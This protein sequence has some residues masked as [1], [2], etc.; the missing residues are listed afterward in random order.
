MSEQKEP[1]EAAKEK[2]DD[3]KIIDILR[4]KLGREPNDQEKEGVLR[5]ASLWKEAENDVQA[6]LSMVH[7]FNGI[8]KSACRELLINKQDQKALICDMVFNGNIRSDVYKNI[9]AIFAT[10]IDTK[11]KDAPKPE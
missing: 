5:M 3:E 1:V 4:G 6:T 11:G 10:Q 9:V 2:T 7:M 8:F